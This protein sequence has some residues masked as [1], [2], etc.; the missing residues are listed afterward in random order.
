[1]TSLRRQ[2][3]LLEVADKAAR[4]IPWGNSN[5][6]SYTLDRQIT[7]AR[8]EMGPVRWAELDKEWNA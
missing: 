4:E 5:A 1:M 8:K 3:R 7:R 6:P 2:A